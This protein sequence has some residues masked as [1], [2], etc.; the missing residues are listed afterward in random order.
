MGADLVGKNEFQFLIGKCEQITDEPTPEKDSPD[1]FQ[2][3]KGKCERPLVEI[4]DIMFPPFQFLKG[5]CER[6]TL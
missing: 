5:K 3:L 4:G 1:E 6:T 2:F